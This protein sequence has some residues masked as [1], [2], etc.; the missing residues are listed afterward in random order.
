VGKEASGRMKNPPT[1]MTCTPTTRISKKI[2]RIL[3]YYDYPVILSTKNSGELLKNSTLRI[4]NSIKKLVVQISVVSAD[5]KFCKVAEPKAPSPQERIQ[6]IKQLSEEGV[7]CICR[8]QPLFLPQM[9]NVKQELIPMLSEAKCQH[10]IL[11]H[12]KLPVERKRR[13]FDTMLKKIN[14]DAYDFYREHG[15]ILVGREWLLPNKIKWANLQPIIERIHKYGMTYGA[16]DYGLNH[17]GDTSCCCGIDN[18][19]GFNNWFRG[20]FSNIIRKSKQEYITFAEVEK[21]WHPKGGIRK[22]L[23]SNCRSGKGGHTML[24]YL[25]SKWNSP[26]TTNAPDAFLGIQWRSDYDNNGNCLYLK[27]KSD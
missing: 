10:V 9:K 25:K 3:A 5:K 22:V 13:S 12:L 1:I 15:M 11:E 19:A 14:W 6:C 21:R 2:L 8:L 16:G 4:L 27:E 17:L 26:G 18:V 24:D 20:N 7:Y 23:N